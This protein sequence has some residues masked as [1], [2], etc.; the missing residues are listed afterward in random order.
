MGQTTSVT[1]EIPDSAG[2]E[3]KEVKLL[4]AARLYEK[5]KLTLGQAAELAGYTKATFMEL[6]AEVGVSVI[7]H[8]AEELEKDLLNARRYHH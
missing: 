7:N 6:L 2:V 5:G 4:V 8:P 1:L 3:A